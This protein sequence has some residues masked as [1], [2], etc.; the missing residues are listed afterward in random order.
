M[1]SPITYAKAFAAALI[2]HLRL[3]RYWTSANPWETPRSFARTVFM[4]EKQ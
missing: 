1:K 3:Y 2:D 4:G